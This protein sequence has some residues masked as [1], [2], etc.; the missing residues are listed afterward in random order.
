VSHVD[1]SAVL[2]VD[3][4]AT[5]ARTVASFRAQ[6]IADRLEVVLVG[7]D[8]V[9]PAGAAAGLAALVTVDAPVRPLSA[10]RAAGISAARGRVVFVAET[11]GFPRPDCLERLLEAIEAGADAAMPRFVNA[12]AETA[13]SWASLFAT[14]GAYTGSTPSALR[15]IALHNGAFARGVLADAATTPSDL[16]YGVGL[17]ERLR[18]RGAVMRFVPAAV[19]DHLNVVAPLG[20]LL[21]RVVGGQMWAGMRARRWPSWRRAA[22]VVG[23]PLAPV[24]MVARI[25][26]SD[27][28]RELRETT[29][30]GTGLALG[31]WAA[32]Q[33]VGEVAG[34]AFGPGDAE[35]RHVELELHREAFL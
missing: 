17:T 29:P 19:V 20:V 7:P 14:Y 10:A 12:N 9:V 6:T 15:A 11:H 34:Y 22:H 23:A 8:V 3:V 1:V 5:G 16:V 33:A 26:A 32:M 31:A 13:R 21:D 28:W 30:R 4:F 27:G 2:A 18:A 24:V 35:D 25:L